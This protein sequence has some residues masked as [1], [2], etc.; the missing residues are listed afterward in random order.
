MLLNKILMLLITHD[1]TYYAY[2]WYQEIYNTRRT[3]TGYD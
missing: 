2:I 1:F 3:Y